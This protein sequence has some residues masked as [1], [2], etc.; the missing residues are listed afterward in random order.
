MA[1]SLSDTYEGLGLEWLF[2]IGAPARASV[3][4]CALY[5]VAPT[6]STSG[7]EVTNANAYSRQSMTMAKTTST[8][9]PNADVTFTEASG[10]WGTVVAMA[11]CDSATHAAGNIICWGDLTANKAID[12]G[13]TAKFV[14]A[15]LSCTLG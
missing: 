2:N 11:M 9:N 8:V 3:V 12:N 13:D 15:N 14:A 4:A 7:T 6:D 10:S 1:G 5:T